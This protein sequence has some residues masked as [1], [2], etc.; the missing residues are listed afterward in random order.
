MV[1][2]YRRNSEQSWL[3][4]LY[5]LKSTMLW[6]LRLLT[7]DFVGSVI[8]RLGKI[9][10]SYQRTLSFTLRFVVNAEFEASIQIILS[11]CLIPTALHVRI[12]PST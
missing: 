12:D 2:N 10:R 8:L 7:K 11:L 1:E 6:S 9:W 4:Q 3:K 5:W